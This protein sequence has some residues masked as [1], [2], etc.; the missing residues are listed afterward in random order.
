MNAREIVG[1]LGG[2]WRGTYGTAKCPAH[3][4]RSPS[5]SVADAEGRV[6]VRCHAGCEQGAILDALRARGLWSGEDTGHRPDPEAVAREQARREAE[7]RKRIEAARR[8][9]TEA[10]PADG[11][12][13]VEYLRGRGIAAPPPSTLRF[14]PAAFHRDTGL[15]LPC[16]VAAVCRWHG[17]QVIATHRTYLRVG[18]DGSVTKAPVT[19]AKMML[20]PVAGGAVRLSAP[21]PVLAVGEGIETCMAFAQATGLPTWAALSTSGLEAVI[22]PP[23]VEVPEVVIC[24]DNDESGAGQRAAEYAASRWEAEGRRVRI[25]MPPNQGTDF[26][27]MLR[28]AA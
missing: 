18:R 8:L 22:L 12:P 3:D 27:D 2:A 11:S 5:L 1:A 23:V 9:W 21:G 13:V 14:H 15:R 28:G 4:D 6:L 7:T 26:N 24:A 16:M 10:R 19:G 25:V 17:G 20:G